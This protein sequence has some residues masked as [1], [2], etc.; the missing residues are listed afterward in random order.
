MW[1]LY[2][3]VVPGFRNEF[4]GPQRRDIPPIGPPQNDGKDR[5]PLGKFILNHQKLK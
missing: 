3:N 5:E 1:P 4:E 2:H